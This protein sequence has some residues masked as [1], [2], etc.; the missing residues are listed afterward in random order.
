MKSFRYFLLRASGLGLIGTSEKKEHAKNNF[1]RYTFMVFAGNI[2]L[3][4]AFAF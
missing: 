1:S 3:V 4:M 2:I